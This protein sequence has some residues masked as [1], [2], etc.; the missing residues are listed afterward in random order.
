MRKNLLKSVATLGISAIMLSSMSLPSH[1]AWEN[2]NGQWW[3]TNES[4]AGYSTGW[5]NINGNWYLFDNA[6]WMTTGWQLV[7][8]QWYYMDEAGAMGANEWVGNYFLTGS[9]AMAKDTWIGD[10]Y[11]GSDGNW[12]QGY[13][14]IE[15]GW[16]SNAKGWWYVDAD[17]SYISNAWAKINGN[18]YLFDDAGW[19]NTGWQLVNGEWYYMN[20]SGA[21]VANSWVGNYYVTESGA[22]ARNTWIGNYYVG[23]NGAWV[24]G[25]TVAGEGWKSNASGWWYVTSNG[26]YLSNSWAKIGGSWYLFDESGWMCIGWYIVDGEYYYMDESGAMATNRWIGNYYLTGSGAMAR[27]TWIGDYYVGNDGAW[28]TAGSSVAEGTWEYN[29]SY[30]FWKFQKTD[31]TY[32]DGWNIIGGEYYY[33]VGNW[34]Y[35]GAPHYEAAYDEYYYLHKDGK[36]ARNEWVDIEGTYK[37]YATENG[38]LDLDQVVFY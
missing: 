11:V 23:S 31:G 19:M 16:K 17:G 28:V 37:I 25:S 7:N 9:G 24:Q 35:A 18:W 15:E 5:E 13:G 12:I 27:N 20:G 26:S 22:M 30:G 10:Y 36:M 3:N 21:M 14:A 32:A 8:G 6:G 38:A 1:A 29:N 33:F 2:S 4:E 34:M